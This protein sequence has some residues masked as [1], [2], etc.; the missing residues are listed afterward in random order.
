E[1][2]MAKNVIRGRTT[3]A[4]IVARFGN[5]F[6]NLDRPE[7]DS[8][9]TITYH[10]Y[11]DSYD[12]GSVVFDFDSRTRVL[13]DWHASYWIC[14]FCPP[15]LAHDGRWRLEGKMLAGRIGADREGPDTLLLP[16]LL[17][18]NQRLSIRLANWAPEM[19]YLDQLQLGV[20]PCEPGHEVDTDLEGYP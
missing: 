7:R 2:W 19:E 20:V 4:D 5:D 10:I 9:R 12:G 16:R 14:G 17:P 1:R 11:G 13:Q 6:F 18:Q 15:V 8:I 3:E